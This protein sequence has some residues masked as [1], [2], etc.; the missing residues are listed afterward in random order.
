M[1]ISRAKESGSYRLDAKLISQSYVDRKTNGK[2]T[3]YA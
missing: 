2:S 3:G 1:M